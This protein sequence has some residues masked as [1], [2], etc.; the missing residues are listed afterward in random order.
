MKG[1]VLIRMSTKGVIALDY[2]TKPGD[3]T[4]DDEGYWY[5]TSNKLQEALKAREHIH[6]QIEEMT[7]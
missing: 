2:Y 4:R 5:L 7:K 3:Y 1:E 6:N